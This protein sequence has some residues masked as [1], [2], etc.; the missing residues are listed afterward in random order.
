[1]NLFDRIERTDT[2][3]ATGAEAGFAYLNRSARADVARVREL[4][5][6]WFACYPAEHQP[7]LARRFRATGRKGLDG[8]TRVKAGVFS[9]SRSRRVPPVEASRACGLLGS[10]QWKGPR[11][12]R[13]TRNSAVP[14]VKDVQ[15]WN[16]SQVQLLLY[17]NP[18]AQRPPGGLIVQWLRRIEGFRALE[19]PA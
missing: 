13:N 19:K 2:G 1:M 10:F 18:Y 4:L 14:V 3:A 15:P 5:E 9:S 11:G 7:D 16:V 17:L 8:S 6:S 12:P